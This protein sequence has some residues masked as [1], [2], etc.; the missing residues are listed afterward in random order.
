MGTCMGGKVSSGRKGSVTVAILAGERPYI[1]V[2]K[3]VLRHSGRPFVLPGAA[4]LRAD[5]GLLF[6]VSGHVAGQV[7]TLSE[8]V[9]ATF[10]RAGKGLFSCVQASVGSHIEGV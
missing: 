2:A 1:P 3:Q 4:W 5:K 8:A 7:H 9:A 6:P 10:M